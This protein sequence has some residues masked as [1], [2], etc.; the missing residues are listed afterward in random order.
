MSSQN[1]NNS[2]AQAATVAANATTGKT[3][4]VSIGYASVGSQAGLDA[5]V[6][7]AIAKGYNPV[8]KLT[9]K[10]VG[11]WGEA[12]LRTADGEIRPLK[13]GDVVKKGDVVLTAQD[14]II[15][16]EGARDTKAAPS[17]IDRVIEQVA[18]GAPEAVTAAGNT[19]G[20]TL[21]EGLRVDRVAEAVTPA[22]F[23]LS[24]GNDQSAIRS[25][26]TA[27]EAPLT[28]DTATSDS[29]SAG[30]G[31]SVTFDPRANDSFSGGNV[32]VTS[33]AGQAIAVGT[34]VTIPQGTVVLNPNGT[35]TFTP[36]PN[37]NGTLNLTYTA[38]DGTG[39]P[40]GAN[41]TI[42]VTPVN[43]APVA[44]DDTVTV[45]EDT[46]VSGN[47]LGNDTDADGDTLT[48]T[49][50]TVDRNGDGTPDTVTP[51]TPVTITTGG[52][53]VGTLLVNPDGTFTFTPASDYNGPVPPV[54]YTVTDGQGGTDTGTLTLVVSP[55][56]D[57]SVLAADT[58]TVA[59]DTLATGN[60]LANDSDKD[61]TLSVGTFTVAGQTAAA[62]GFVTV[63]GV[64]TLTIA[65]NGAYTFAP[66]AGYSGT[67]PTATYTTNT[68]S[69]ATLNI[70]VT[71]APAPPPPV[72]QPS[73]LAP[74][75][76]TVAEDSVAT[77]N[78]LANDSDADDVLSVASF[79]VAGLPGTFAAGTTATIAGVGTLVI[80]SNGG[81]TFTPVADYNGTVP[82]VSYTT[83]TGSSSTLDI[84][85]TPLDDTPAASDDLA[86]TPEDTPVTID[87]L[88]NDTDA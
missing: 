23:N 75:T 34:P 51:G 48:V 81:Y 21:G 11:V 29:V 60:V 22:G 46:P 36:T 7:A 14:G 67:V 40:V 80:N 82:Q 55:V 4:A 50:V 1:T 52:T 49:A 59:Q 38:T 6:K 57:A 20:D 77:G 73:V 45:T 53:P 64:G 44:N 33:V 41:I 87:V 19:P 9:G 8:R 63:A 18:Q 47:V 32:T 27:Q 79:S 66:A 85:V 30:E 62:G 84:N 86:T 12:L 83:N 24:G 43:D 54:T 28:P 10:V 39:T 69:S 37:F 88:A 65:S 31:S 5:S 3:I 71:P 15:Q 68:G 72:D 56:D 74:D 58:N 70:E 2:S 61:S 13:V 78:V 76:K 42:T 17:E 26:E 35:L 25:F 16:I